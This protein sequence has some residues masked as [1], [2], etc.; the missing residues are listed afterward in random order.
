MATDL[1]KTAISLP[2]D[3]RRSQSRE[4]V[5]R[6]R[7]R[8]HAGEFCITLQLPAAETEDVLIELGFLSAALADDRTAV[9]DALERFVRGAI[10]GGASSL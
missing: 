8:R 10:L 2:E 6:H 7:R 4:R 5:T 1:V 3:T 9:R